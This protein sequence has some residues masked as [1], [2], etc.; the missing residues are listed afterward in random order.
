MTAIRYDA[1]ERHDGRDYTFTIPILDAPVC[2]ACKEMV[3]TEKVDDQINAALR[4]HLHLRAA[5]SNHDSAKHDP[6]PPPDLAH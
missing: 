3:V 6:T 5:G 1:E 2:R 4:S